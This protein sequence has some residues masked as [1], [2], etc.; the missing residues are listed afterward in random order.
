MD[1][2]AFH[3]VHNHNSA[4]GLQL[5]LSWLHLAAKRVIHEKQGFSFVV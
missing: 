2:T 1:G 5:A 3:L 4:I